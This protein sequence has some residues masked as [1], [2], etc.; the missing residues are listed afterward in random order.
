MTVGAPEV[1]A[2]RPRDLIHAYRVWK[3]TEILDLSDEQMYAFFSRLKDMD[4]IEA[5]L[6]EDERKTVRDI[7]DLLNDEEVD[8]AELEKALARHSNVRRKR[9]EEVAR[10]R[11]EAMTMLGVRQRAQYLV[12]DERF[13]S[14]LRTIIENARDMQRQQRMEERRDLWDDDFGSPGGR[15]GGRGGSGRGRR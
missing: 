6:L 4:E 9:L 10:L 8:E 3:L 5:E 7:A 2:E 13:R 15:A 1:S 12:F 14:E 11:D